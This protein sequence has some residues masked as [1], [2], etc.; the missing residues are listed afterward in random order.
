M[1]LGPSLRRLH[2]SLVVPPI[3]LA[4][5][6]LQATVMAKSSARRVGVSTEIRDGGYEIVN[7]APGMPAD[8]A[9]VRAGDRIVAIDGQ[10]V[11]READYDEAAS[12]FERGRPVKFELARGGD[13]VAATIVPGA[14]FPWLDLLLGA[15]VS[16]AFL[17]IGFL[18]LR[19]R[20]AYLASR[21]LFLFVSLVAI[22]F[23]MPSF[24]IGYP[25]LSVA[26][27]VI[28][29]LLTGAQA[30]LVLHLAAVI[31]EPAR[32]VRRWPRVIP[33][34]YITCWLVALAPPVTM[35]LEAAGWKS[36]PWSSSVLQLWVSNRFL[37]LWA[38]ATVGLLLHPA[39]L[40]P[41]PAGRR[42]ARLVLAGAL[43]WA[44]VTVG[45]AFVELPS[46]LADLQSLSVLGYPLGILAALWRERAM[47]ERVLLD[48]SQEVQRVSS[49]AEV[50]SVVGR[51]LQLA[52]QPEIAYVF[53]RDPATRSLRLG[54]ASGIFSAGALA[55]ELELV[56]LLERTGQTVAYPEEIP[57]ELPKAERGWLDAMRVRLVVPI[58]GRQQLLVGLLLLGGK[59][60]G[61]PFGE[62]DR[63]LL[64]SLASQIG[65]LYENLQLQREVDRGARTQRQVLDRL[66]A[67]D[68]NLVQECP[69]C[70]ACYDSTTE[71]CSVDGSRLELPMAVERVVGGRYRL[72]RLVGKGGM[73]SV[74]E[75]WDQERERRVAV[76][77]LA[78]LFFGDS[79][80]LR[81]F[82]REARVS[83]RLD[84]P[85]V[86]KVFDYGTTATGGAYMVMELLE[87]TTLR[88]AIRSSGRIP[89]RDLAV[90]V[91]GI[92]DGLA[93]A[94]A[95]QVVHRDLKPANIF[96]S[97]DDGGGPV[98]KLVDFGLAKVRS[99][100]PEEMT[101]LTTPGLLLGT[102]TYMAPEHLL[103]A[104]IDARSDIF[105]LG[106][107]VVE[108]Y[109]GQPPFRCTTVPELITAIQ[110][111][112][113]SLP[114]DSAAERRFERALRRCLAPSPADRPASVVEA[115]RDLLPA[116]AALAG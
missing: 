34:I 38:A 108:A 32:W 109:T 3:V 9:G 100:G 94:H 75:A 53:F 71:R 40:Y 63:K 107:V 84:H 96:M 15:V 25:V 105:A 30:G 86:V 76:K 4:L 14:P 20:P 77:V 45:S 116:L 62:H 12:E 66:E 5:L 31:P 81:R 65:L 99:S 55:P 101:S 33:A 49:L 111:G 64:L 88:D 47:Q 73:G 18:A 70:G 8:R 90:W 61:E 39:F 56:R 87:G 43:P 1:R 72:D 78:P 106:V 80:A 41:Q 104:E 82:E 36:L 19:F 89:P 98:V 102:L 17:A 50:S 26:T 27:T 48:L 59:R 11:H 24:L 68:V 10:P 113:F 21:I 58:A 79:E 37:P 74:Y 23:A 115:R 46:S 29:F 103:G 83:A 16:L 85:N 35:A 97:R 22:E 92:C 13:P 52:F 57:S 112:G 110:A 95:M 2:P 6:A 44:I 114:G 60:S 69:R 7:V 28:Y 91:E 42:L 51:N 67:R 93:A 54:L